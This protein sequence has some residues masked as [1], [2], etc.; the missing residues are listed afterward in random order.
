MLLCQKHIIQYIHTYSA[1]HLLNWPINVLPALISFSENF[2]AFI[3]VEFY[4]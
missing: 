2:Q 3:R 1:L 4:K